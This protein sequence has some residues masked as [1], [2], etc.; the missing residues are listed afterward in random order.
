MSNK[1]NYTIYIE[2]IH[3]YFN[4]FVPLTDEEFEQ[5]TPYFEI[6]EFEKKVQVVKMGEID[7]YFNIIM[8]GLVRKYTIVGK[9]DVTLQLSIEGQMIHS[10][11]SFNTQT[12]SETI[13]ETIEPTIFFS[14]S[15]DNL[16]TVY[17]LFPKIE[18]LARL[19]ITYMFIKKDFR[20]FSQLKKTTRE[21]FID[22]M[23][24]HPD[25]LQRVPQ[26]YIASYLNIKPETFSRLKH[27]MQRKK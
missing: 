5:L 14:M 4:G 8:K 17:R 27:L 10:E 9:K 18:K 7:K 25:M 19:V 13:V 26:K 12:P 6:R 21:R 15:Y 22:Y 20:D 2:E 16:Q 1:N 23:Q 11:I 3:R 24:S